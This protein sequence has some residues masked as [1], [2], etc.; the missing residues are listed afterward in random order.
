[1][2]EI[3]DI[4]RELRLEKDQVEGMKIPM[5][6]FN[7]QT[8]LFK[9]VHS[10][11]QTDMTSKGVQDLENQVTDLK[12][13]N[14]QLDIGNMHYEEELQKLK[15]DVKSK[16]EQ[17]IKATIASK[18][19]SDEYQSDSAP[20]FKEDNDNV[21]ITE[22]GRVGVDRK[23]F[24]SRKTLNKTDSVESKVRSKLGSLDH[25]ISR[26]RSQD[27]S[28]TKLNKQ[29][30]YCIDCKR[31]RRRRR[32]AKV[33]PERQ[34]QKDRLKINKQKD[35]EQI[36]KTSSHKILRSQSTIL[37]KGISKTEDDVDESEVK[38]NE[39]IYS[40]ASFDSVYSWT[41]GK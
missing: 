5:F 31:R 24:K 20:S 41:Y 34:G 25:S 11:V 9:Q 23:S 4:N 38:A 12:E 32:S 36:K 7:Q 39:S 35:S 40:G 30:V 14:K 22:E 18:H 17:L 33:R 19:Q 37:V 28:Q 21:F 26:S 6:D 27:R 10:L 16:D 29:Y 13:L 15:D 1:M 2:T 8:T 3:C